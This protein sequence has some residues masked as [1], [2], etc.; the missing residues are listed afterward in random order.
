MSQSLDFYRSKATKSVQLRLTH[1]AR[2]TPGEGI[3]N[4]MSSSGPRSLSSIIPVPC[5]FDEDILKLVTYRCECG[6]NQPISKL[7][8]CRHCVAQRCPFCVSHEVDSH[9]CP[10]CLENMPSAE[11]KVKKN[12]CASCFDCPSCSHTLST[13]AT[14]ATAQ[15]AKD[16]EKAVPK[17]VYYLACS[18]C[19]WTSR[20][21]GLPDQN[22]ASGGWPDPENSSVARLALL[23]D[24]YRTLAQQE[25]LEK[26]SKRYMGKKL[27]YAA[28]SEKY[29]VS[30]AARRRTGLGSMGSPLSIGTQK[31]EDDET[32][33][34]EMCPAEAKDISDVEQ[35]PESL[36]EESVDLCE[37]NTLE[38]RILN[39]DVKDSSV[40]SLYP[41]HK[42]LMIKRS[43]RCRKCDHNLSKPEYNPSSIKFK[44]QL[45]AYYHVPE[46]ILSKV[47][48]NPAPGQMCHFSIR[49][50]NPTQHPTKIEFV[51]METYEE[52][53]KKKQANKEEAKEKEEKKI[54][55][56]RN[57]TQVVA[58][59]LHKIEP[60]AECLVPPGSVFVPPRDDTAEFDDSAPDLQGVVDDKNVVLSRKSNKVWV[61][62]AAK[63]G[64]SL[65]VGD[66]VITTI[67]V[68]FLFTNTLSA[69][70]QKTI[71]AEEVYIPINICL[72]NVKE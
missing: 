20:D 31:G 52:E 55:L 26:E 60:T 13:R 3:I 25:K 22:V 35:L 69:L 61:R 2:D 58:S 46:V 21:I 1:P 27:S 19:R 9:Y 12:R 8:F 41:K 48:S 7:Y 65:S 23:Q 56:L 16:P 32:K 44:I 17:K 67:G 66:E 51:S 14:S 57:S 37:L 6:A 18:F 45:A 24:H 68:K 70:E 54:G 49:I 71:Q 72:G 5:P 33:T 34:A 43:Q 39:L 36:F 53:M 38:Q 15:S 11:A 30:L 42:H 50:S 10:C 29:G 47:E 64:D 63:V 4:K 40:K 59:D 28:L 62:L